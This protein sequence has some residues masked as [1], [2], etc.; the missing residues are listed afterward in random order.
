MPY[1]Q[2][3]FT[4]WWLFY[5]ATIQLK[6]ELS[7][8]SFVIAFFISLVRIGDRDGY[9]KKNNRT[10][11]GSFYIHAVM[12]NWN[13]RCRKSHVR[14]HKNTA[15]NEGRE[16]K[17][18]RKPLI[19]EVDLDVFLWRHTWH[20]VHLNDFYKSKNSSFKIKH[21]EIFLNSVFIRKLIP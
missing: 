8:S 19:K 9:Y 21:W 11:K 4:A 7:F 16:E 20:F 15:K 1:C 3:Y 12:L 10:K 14:H 6:Y 13:G 17:W 2:H 5:T 18:E